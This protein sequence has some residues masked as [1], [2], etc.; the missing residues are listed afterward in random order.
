LTIDNLN[1]IQNTLFGVPHEEKKPAQA[2]PICIHYMK[3]N[4]VILPNNFCVTKKLHFGLN[5][6]FKSHLKNW[7]ALGYIER[8]CHT[9]KW[10]ND[11]EKVIINCSY[12]KKKYF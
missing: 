11:A 3:I 5:Y 7:G 6:P 10:S 8:S 9:E 2:S 12:Y 4:L 1:I